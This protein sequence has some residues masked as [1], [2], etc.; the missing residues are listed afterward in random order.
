MSVKW[1]DMRMVK[2]GDHSRLTLEALASF[3]IGGEL[4]GKNLDR[5]CP[6]QAGIASTVN[7]THTARTQWG[8]DLIGTEF[9]A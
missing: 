4:D 9:H 7:F 1:A 5:Y 8:L 2:I 3:G 6:V